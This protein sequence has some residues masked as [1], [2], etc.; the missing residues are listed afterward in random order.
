MT[1]RMILTLAAG[2][3]ACLFLGGVVGILLIA[4]AATLGADSGKKKE[5]EKIARLIEQLGNDDFEK[6]EAA[7]KELDSIGESAISALRKVVASSPDAEIRRRA[8]TIIGAIRAH[9]TQL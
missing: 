2:M 3:R 7:S 9:F 5:A 1:R 4:Q 6:R 8:E